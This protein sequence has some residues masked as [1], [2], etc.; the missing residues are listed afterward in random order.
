MA[1]TRIR[2]GYPAA[3]EVA[4]GEAARNGT[5][6]QRF[7][8]ARPITQPV[9]L[10]WYDRR[11][12]RPSNLPTPC[13]KYILRQSRGFPKGIMT[14]AKS[15]LCEAGQLASVF[16]ARHELCRFGCLLY[17]LEVGVETQNVPEIG[18]QTR[19]SSQAKLD[20]GRLILPPER[21]SASRSTSEFS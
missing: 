12:W 11:L 10:G 21:G 6:F 8:I 7:G 17:M 2:R 1:Q 20:I 9:G 14:S 4:D 16:E 19:V 15:A 18:L 13:G 3:Q 5:R